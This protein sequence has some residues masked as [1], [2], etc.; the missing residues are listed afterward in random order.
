MPLPGRAL[1]SL[2]TRFNGSSLLIDCGEG[3][4]VTVREKGWSMHDVDA[5]L[6]THYHGDHI[7]GLPGILLSMANSDRTE[8]VKLYGPPGLRRVVNALCIIAPGLPFELEFNEFNDVEEY[9]SLNGYEITAFKVNHN[10]T[11]YG[12]T[13]YIPR[14]GKFDPEKAKNNNVPMKAWN[15]LQKGDNVEMDGVIYTPDM[16]LGPKRKGLKVTYTTDTRPTEGIVEHAKG[17]DLF[18]CEGMY[19]DP[20]KRADAIKK[21]HMTM[22]EAAEMAARADVGELWYTHYSPSLVNPARNIKEMKEIFPRAVA[23]K[24]RRT[25]E[26]MF[27]ED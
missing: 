3:T 23:A 2:M 21:K 14:A 6:F 10:V 11:C 9:I 16:I 7:S 1:T 19:A 15:R 22:Q 26:L 5:M 24:D 18:I 8:P 13:I 17:S 25:V 27:E 20:E 4:Q 12:Y